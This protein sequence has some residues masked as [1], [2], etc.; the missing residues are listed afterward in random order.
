MS[1]SP[2]PVGGSVFLVSEDAAMGLSGPLRPPSALLGLGR[3]SGDGWQQL[4]FGDHT[5]TTPKTERIWVLIRNRME[6]AIRHVD[7]ARKW[8]SRNYLTH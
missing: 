7:G 8:L 1:A 6:T 4:R 2:R 5:P 3:C